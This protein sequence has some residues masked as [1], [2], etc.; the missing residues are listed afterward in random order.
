MINLWSYAIGFGSAIPFL[1]AAIYTVTMFPTMLLG[2]ASGIAW[3]IGRA[4]AG[5]VG[6]CTGPI[7]AFFSGSYAL[8]A[9]TIMS[10]YILGFVASCFVREPQEDLV[11]IPVTKYGQA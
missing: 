4:F 6:L 1:V 11:S 3:G 8:A 10:V 5:I 9:A 7:I 2:T